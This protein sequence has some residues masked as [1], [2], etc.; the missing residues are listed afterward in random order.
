MLWFN[1]L[2]GTDGRLFLTLFKLPHFA[3]AAFESVTVSNESLLKI[4][5]FNCSS[6]VISFVFWLFANELSELL[7]FDNIKLLCVELLNDVT[8]FDLKPLL[9]LFKEG[10]DVWCDKVERLNFSA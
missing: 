1:R 3:I 10:V 5:F 2:A 6:A 8:L 7:L 9:I 4:N